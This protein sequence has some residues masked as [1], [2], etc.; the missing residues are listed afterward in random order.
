MDARAQHHSTK[1]LFGPLVDLNG[2]ACKKARASVAI[3]G[4]RFQ[5]YLAMRRP[6]NGVSTMCSG[7]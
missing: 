7:V 6:R 5:Y 2:L 4:K 1:L 3:A